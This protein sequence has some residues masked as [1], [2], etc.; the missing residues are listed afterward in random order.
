MAQV[1]PDVL[2]NFFDDL[3]NDSSDLETYAAGHP[4]MAD[5]LGSLVE[6][7]QSI[8]PPPDVSLDSVTRARMRAGLLYQMAQTRRPAAK[9]R[10]L[11]IRESL[12]RLVG[13][14]ASVERI[15]AMVVAA[16][17]VL[18]TSFGGG[19]V[20]AAEGALPGD[21]LYPVKLSYENVQLVLAPNDDAKA[22]ALVHLAYNRLTDLD[23]ASLTGRVEAVNVAASSY[24]TDVS[25]A[26]QILSK[27]T[28]SDQTVTV[29]ADRLEMDLARHESTIVDVE[30]QQ[31]RS[32]A[33][34]ALQ[35]ADADVESALALAVARDQ[36]LSQLLAATSTSVGQPAARTMLTAASVAPRAVV[37][38]ALPTPGSATVA[39]TGQPT[40]V[41]AGA[42]VN[43]GTSAPV[44]ATAARP[45]GTSG[46]AGNPK[47]PPPSGSGGRAHDND[48]H[49]PAVSYWVFHRKWV[50][51][52]PPRPARPVTKPQP[53]SN[54]H[55]GA[56]AQ[57]A[58]STA[59]QHSASVA[60]TP[61]K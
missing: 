6:V 12:Q 61:N 40:T 30:T 19:V 31:P 58:S 11:S 59:N 7:A 28:A 45:G 27:P 16:V 9:E 52:V 47:A 33:T 2:A 36:N 8:A 42:P 39:Q 41:A 57:P 43:G 21:A 22:A 38:V 60:A 3:E 17:I 26:S 53:V 14:V 37:T 15:P 56:A 24:A 50:L 13:I 54:A 35:R 34:M 46:S 55:G 5:D 25:E 44:A 32:V 1:T 20:F 23:K 49:R 29:L 4:K 51:A 18:A 10:K 48:R